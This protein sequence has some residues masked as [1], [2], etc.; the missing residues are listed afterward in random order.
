[1]LPTLAKLVLDF[2]IKLDKPV[3]VTQPN[4]LMTFGC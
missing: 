2:N 4:K 1:M 3:L